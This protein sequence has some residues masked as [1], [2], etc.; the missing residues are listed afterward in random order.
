MNIIYQT[1]LKITLVRKHITYIAVYIPCTEDRESETIWFVYGL[2]TRVSENGTSD[3]GREVN[4][5]EVTC[6]IF[7]VGELCQLSPGHTSSHLSLMIHSLLLA[8][9]EGEEGVCFR[10]S[11][12]WILSSILSL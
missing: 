5:K 6:Y 11:E 1:L 3:G 2:E 12:S 9:R 7:S 10:V 8:T 4:E